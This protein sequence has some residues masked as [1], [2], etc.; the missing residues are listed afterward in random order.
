ME[1]EKIILA[2]EKY[3]ELYDPG[4]P[5]ILEVRRKEWE[6]IGRKV[7]KPGKTLYIL[8]IYFF[9]LQMKNRL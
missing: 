6:E 5:Y 4:N 2:I 8:F 3:K 9:I 1:E 7:Q